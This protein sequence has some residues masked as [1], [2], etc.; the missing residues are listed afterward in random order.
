MMFKRVGLL[1][2]VIAT[3]AAAATGI[4]PTAAHAQEAETAQG[5]DG[6]LL[7]G[8]GVL[9]A[10]GDGLVAVKGRIDLYASADGGVLL[11][12]DIAGDAAVRV[13]GDGRSA[14]WQ[15]F[16][17]YFGF[18]GQARVT[19]SNVAVIVVGKDIRLHVVGIGWAYLKGEGTFEVNNR[20]P[21][22]W[23]PEGTF[24]GVGSEQGE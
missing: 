2:L 7:V 4:W 13:D 8:R 14:S 18:E 21:F 11:V 24:V 5:R 19:G 20:G 1:A 22:R 15:G 12:K 10:R 6:T 9:D 23:T 17:A 3:I 16:T